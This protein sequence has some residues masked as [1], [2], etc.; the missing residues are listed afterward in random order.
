MTRGWFVDALADAPHLRALV[1]EAAEDVGRF[2]REGRFAR[3]STR[4]RSAASC[5]LA[6]LPP[7]M[8]GSSALARWYRDADWLAYLEKQLG[9]TAEPLPPSDPRACVVYVYDRP[10]D[11]H[12]Q[13]HLDVGSGAVPRLTVLTGLDSDTDQLF[14]AVF[15]ARAPP[16]PPSWTQAAALLDPGMGGFA[17]AALA[18]LPGSE[19]AAL[20]LR[21]FDVVAF[22]ADRCLHRVTRRSTGRR[23]VVASMP[24]GVRAV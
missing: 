15:L 13:W 11:H 7:S 17:A 6:A 5:P 21:R 1:L 23:R 20:R 18:A 9:E 16:W 14:E 8:R 2:Q 24:Y 12:E 22:R 10:E 19:R 3:A 4:Q